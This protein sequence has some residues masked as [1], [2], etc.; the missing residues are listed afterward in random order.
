MPLSLL[1][2]VAPA[3]A[4]WDTVAAGPSPH[5]ATINVLASAR[6]LPVLAALVGWLD[7]NARRRRAHQRRRAGGPPDAVVQERRER[8]RG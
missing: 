4:G 6:T 1:A 7:Q 8:V 3:V 5:S 2:S